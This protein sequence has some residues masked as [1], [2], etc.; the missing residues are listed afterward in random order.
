LATVANLSL[1]LTAGLKWK[2]ARRFQSKALEWRKAQ[3]KP[4]A[5]RASYVGRV[6]VVWQGGIHLAPLHQCGELTPGRAERKELG[7]RQQL[8]AKGNGDAASLK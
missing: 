1:T 7:P 3:K 4:G 5:R 6:C 2:A 8:L